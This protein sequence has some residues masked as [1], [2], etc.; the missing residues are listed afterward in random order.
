[1]SAHIFFVSAHKKIVSTDA[2]KNNFVSAQEKNVSTEVR[3]L[4]T[5]PGIP[6][7]SY[8]LVPNLRQCGIFGLLLVR[9]LSVFRFVGYGT[10]D[11]SIYF[12]LRDFFYISGLLTLTR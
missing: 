6:K 1:M 4:I 11:V 12:V 7:L 10:G 8:D 9:I 5:V 3:D 2:H